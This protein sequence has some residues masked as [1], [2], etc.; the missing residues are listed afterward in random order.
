MI[1]KLGLQQQQN[2]SCRLCFY[3]L[4]LYF[5]LFQI[6]I[7]T[8]AIFSISLSNHNN[9]VM[10]LLYITN[11]CWLDRPSRNIF[12]HLLSRYSNKTGEQK[13][14]VSKEYDMLADIY[15]YIYLF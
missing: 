10:Y 4:W 12:F 13:S 8:F 5:Y 2:I 9:N 6:T 11:P 7:T 3:Q 15:T 1:Y 14:H